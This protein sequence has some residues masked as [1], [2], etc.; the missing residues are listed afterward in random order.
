MMKK[1]FNLALLSAIALTGTYVFTACSSDEPL[2]AEEKAPDS[3]F[4]NPAT[5]EVT[6]QFVLNVSNGSDA[7]TRQSSDAT[8]ASSALTASKF[9][10]IED[11]YIMCAKVTGDGNYL[12]TATT[13]DK[14]ISM[15]RVAA[16][17]TLSN[18]K[19]RRVLEMSLP[20]NTNT[21]LFYG[22]AIQGENTHAG[23]NTY[24]HLADYTVAADL[25]TVNFQLGKRLE[26]T[27]E[28]TQF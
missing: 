28:K 13:V 4:Y 16:A 27:A 6:T 25:T 8:Q 5:N 22:R 18:D 11:S 19:S 21:M 2:A 20:L 14:A 12:A 17:G 23:H 1:Y 26:T 10:G 15:A 3:P 24:G 7:T 9:R